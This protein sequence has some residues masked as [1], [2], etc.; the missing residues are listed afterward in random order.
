LIRKV[1]PGR[2]IQSQRDAAHRA[3]AFD[4]PFRRARGAAHRAGYRRIHILLR[5]EG[6]PINRKRTYRLYREAAWRCGGASANAS[7]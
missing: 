4:S 6:W 2:R 1:N 3:L 7:G 5:R